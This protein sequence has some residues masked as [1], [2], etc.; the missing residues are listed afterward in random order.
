MRFGVFMPTTND[1]YIL[2]KAS[3]SFAPTYELNRAV[4]VEAERSGFGFV[5]AMTKFR[6]YGDGNGFWDQSIDP[7]G[8]IGALIESTSTLEL[9]GSV[10]A[11]TIHPAM[12]ARMAATFDEASQGRFSLNIVAGWNEAEYAQMGLWPENYHEH[13]YRYAG[14][15]IEVLR[16]LWEHGRLTHHGEFFSLD[17]CLVQPRPPH[18]VKVIVPGQSAKSLALSAALAD[19]N[20]IMGDLAAVAVA[21]RQLLEACGG[22]GRVVDSASLYGVITAPTDEEALE[23]AHDYIRNTDYDAAAGLKNAAATDKQGHA[24]GR[25]SEQQDIELIDFDHPTHAAVV[26]RPCFFH[27]HLVG[28]YD[29]VAAYLDALENESGVSNAVLSFPDFRTDLSSFA[30]HVMPRMVTAGAAV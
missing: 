1:G 24:V 8:L 15:Y 26:Q 29:R 14:E 6:G 2:S 18:G 9:W 16:G 25:F 11:P 13:R 17:D 22:T 4:A 12:T 23:Q 19:I 27:P 7:L 20:F 5:L 30:L 10:A 3:P 21:R 28:S